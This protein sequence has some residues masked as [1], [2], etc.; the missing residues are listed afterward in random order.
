MAFV[1]GNQEVLVVV[2]IDRQAH[3]HLRVVVTT[4]C[5][6]ACVPG[7]CIMTLIITNSTSLSDQ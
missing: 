6:V 2:G 7:L 5:T 4:N 3:K 1:E